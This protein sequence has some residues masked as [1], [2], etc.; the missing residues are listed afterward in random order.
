MFNKI[1]IGSDI[2]VFL[3]D[4]HGPVSAVGIIEGDKES[5]I[6]FLPGFGLQRDNVMAEF[7]IPPVNLGDVDSFVTHIKTCLEHIQEV[8]PSYMSLLIKPSVEM[9]EEDLQTEEACQF[10]CSPFVD[11]WKQKSKIVEQE[12]IYAEDVANFRFCGGH[13][14]IGWQGSSLGYNPLT[15]TW[16]D[17]EEMQKKMFLASLC[18]IFLYIPSF[19]EDTD[20]IRRQ[21]YG[22]PGKVR[23]KEYGIEYRSLSNYFCQNESFMQKIME[24]LSAMIEYANMVHP[25]DYVAAFEHHRQIMEKFMMAEDKKAAATECSLACT[26]NV[27]IPA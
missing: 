13:I 24:R 9:E 15:E 23:F 1:T 7:N 5:P 11:I 6:E 22:K 14:H 26:F 18:D 20:D 25:S 19:F 17:E 12:S 3:Q 2:E 21:Y 27:N 8:I 16:T 4:S 10:G